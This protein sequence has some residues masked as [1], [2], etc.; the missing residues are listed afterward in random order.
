MVHSHRFPEF[1]LNSACRLMRQARE[2]CKLRQKSREAEQK[3]GFF[4][5]LSA[6]ET[7][8]AAQAGD[9]ALLPIVSGARAY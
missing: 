9:W 2:S 8:S 7:K 6:P 4:R 5:V 3:G 1:S